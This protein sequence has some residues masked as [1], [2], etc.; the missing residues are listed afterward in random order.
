VLAVYP[1]EIRDDGRAA[2]TLV[3]YL[4]QLTAGQQWFVS[5]PIDN[6]AT[7]ETQVV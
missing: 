7:R 1:A 5:R 2:G 3:N 4:P 6:S